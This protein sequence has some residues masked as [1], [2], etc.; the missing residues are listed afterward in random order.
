MA[1]RFFGVAQGGKLAKDVTEQ[2]TTPG[3]AYEFQIANTTATGAT[4]IECLNALE[5]I[6]NYIIADT[7]PPA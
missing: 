6:K 1:A 4:K 2:L 7:W 3:L 5:A